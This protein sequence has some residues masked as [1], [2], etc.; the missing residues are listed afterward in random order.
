MLS[1]GHLFL[2]HSSWF[3]GSVYDSFSYLSHM[4]RRKALEYIAVLLLLSPLLFINIRDSHAWGDD[5]AGY[6]IQAQDIAAGHRYYETLMVP[7]DY[8]PS[9]APQYYSYGFPLLLA[10][11]VKVWGLDFRALDTY[12]SLW[13]VAWGLLVFTFLRWRF[14]FFTAAAFILIVFINPWF[15]QFKTEIISD[16]PFSFFFTLSLLL[17][18]RRR[19]LSRVALALSGVIAAFTIGIREAGYIFPILLAG[20]ICLQ[21]IRI[22]LHSISSDA[23]RQRLRTDGTMLA[24]TIGAVLTANVVLFP[25]PGSHLEHFLGLYETPDRSLTFLSNL[26]LYTRLYQSLFSHEAGRYSFMLYYTTSFML[27]LTVLG[28][29]Q[30]VWRGA[31][32]WVVLV[33]YALI[34]LFFP[35]SSQGFRYML[36]VLPVLMLCAAL[37][38]QSLR[39]PVGLHRYTAGMAFTIFMVLV[40]VRDI[41]ALHGAQGTTISPGP[42]TASSRHMLDY[43]RTHTAPDALIATTKPRAIALYTGRRTCLIPKNATAGFTSQEL[44]AV[45]PD[46]VLD[47]DR[48]DKN[49]AAA[50]ALYDGDSVIWQCDSNRLYRAKGRP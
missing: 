7:Q 32:E 12:L 28:F 13:L 37:G 39:L 6:L 20:D 33:A 48:L 8:M 2:C 15:F 35:Y 27:V 40:N 4:I 5:F 34:V 17:F 14:S 49:V 23:W 1:V 38:A 50:Y 31:W 24:V 29:I 19:E 44:R 21:T 47:I 9:Y 18:L 41:R 26:D 45:R 11:V 16:I 22:S 42:Q 3:M 36:P 30:I 46:Y 43:I 25:A 10:P